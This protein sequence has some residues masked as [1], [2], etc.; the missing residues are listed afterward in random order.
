MKM[1]FYDKERNVIM[2]IGVLDYDKIRDL[3]L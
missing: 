3:S 1:S 2:M